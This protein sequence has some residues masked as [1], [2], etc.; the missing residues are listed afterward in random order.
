MG[1]YILLGLVVGG[2][3]A[4]AMW[5]NPAAAIRG[6]IAFTILSWLAFSATRRR[7]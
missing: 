5:G 3:I 1:F 7:L 6:A 2:T 4:A